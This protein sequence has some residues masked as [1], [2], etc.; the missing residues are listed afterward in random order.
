MIGSI[1]HQIN[2]QCEILNSDW[3]SG[4]RLGEHGKSWE[5][6]CNAAHFASHHL[7]HGIYLCEGE[8]PLSACT[9]S[10]FQFRV[11]SGEHSIPI[12]TIFITRLR[13]AMAELKKKHTYLRLMMIFLLVFARC[14]YSRKYYSI[15]GPRLD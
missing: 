7:F 12:C 13:T 5:V 14:A 9:L 10:Y 2:S 8:R 6:F 1:R 15:N 4:L 11:I 3:L